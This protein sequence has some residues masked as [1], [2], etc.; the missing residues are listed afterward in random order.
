MA[1]MSSAN[2][3]GTPRKHIKEVASDRRQK[4]VQ[5]RQQGLTYAEIGDRIGVSRS[6]AW[7]Y[8][9]QHERGR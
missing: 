6:C 3:K 7:Q 8:V 2:T 1:S 9:W 4:A 5:L